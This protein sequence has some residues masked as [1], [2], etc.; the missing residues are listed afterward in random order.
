VEDEAE[1]QALIS[2]FERLEEMWCLMGK[3]P[4]PNDTVTNVPTGVFKCLKFGQ[5]S[6]HFT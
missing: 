6:L 3:K 4:K 1:R 5:T 2:F